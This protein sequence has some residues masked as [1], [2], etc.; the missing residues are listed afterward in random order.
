MISDSRLD[1]VINP[2]TLY[3]AMVGDWTVEAISSFGVTT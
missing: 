2:I 1:K 3:Y